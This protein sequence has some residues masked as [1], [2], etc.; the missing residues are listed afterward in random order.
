MVFF[1]F[2]IYYRYVSAR[3]QSCKEITAVL[4]F[5][6]ASLG[7]IAINFWP[8]HAKGDQPESGWRLA[9]G[10]WRLAVGKK[11]SKSYSQIK[12]PDPSMP[13]PSWRLWDSPPLVLR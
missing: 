10:G 8:Y 11:G 7:V 5:M 4:R 3:R 12:G 9:V 2:E 13:A 1:I 6:I